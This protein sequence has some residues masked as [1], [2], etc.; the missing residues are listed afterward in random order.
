MFAE[1]SSSASKMTA[2]KVVD[3]TARLPGCDGQAA[4]AVSAYTSIIGGCS[5]IA[6]NSQ[7]QNVQMFGHVFHDTSG[8]NHGEKGRSR[9]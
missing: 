2:A 6:Q 3:V 1:L 7:N 9:A 8:P 4:D 5:K